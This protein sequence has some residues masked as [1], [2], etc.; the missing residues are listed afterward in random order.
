[1]R[2]RGKEGRVQDKKG[3]NMSDNRNNTRNGNTAQRRQQPKMSKKAMRKKR[4]RRKLIFLIIELIV[5]LLVLAGLWVMLK[6]SK[7]DTDDTFGENV[8]NEYLAEGTKEILGE[9]TTI[10]L[11][12]LDNRSNGEYKSGNS[13]VIM[14]ARIDNETKEVKLVSVYRDTMLNMEDTSDDYTYGK[15]NAAYALGGP[16]RAVKMLNINLDLDITEYVAFDF[17]AVAEAVDLLGGVEIELTAEEIGYMNEY[18][19]ETA[20]VTGK[21]YTQLPEKAGTY[22]LNG[23]QA[24]SY[25]RIRYTSGG[26]FKRSERQREVLN[27]MVEK[28]LSSDI[29]TINELINTVFPEIKTSLSKTEILS[30]AA[31]VFSYS[32]GESIGFPLDLET[33]SYKVSTQ[34]KKTSCVVAA[35]LA[36]NVKQLHEFLYGTTDYEVSE[37]VQ[38]ISDEIINRTGVTAPEKDTEE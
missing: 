9:Y 29:G 4:R 30:L 22:N 1:M 8:E 6:L 36:S 38:N 34:K 26:D 17:N 31:D 32:M 15:A 10:A 25:A 18:C 20:A 37:S 24:V 28:A 27:K 13:D 23:V 21:S 19:V 7:I 5:L 2:N 11:F 14:V 16:D 3:E 33:G 12:G 35:D